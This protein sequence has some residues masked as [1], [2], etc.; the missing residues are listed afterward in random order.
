VPELVA[1]D[2][3]LGEHARSMGAVRG[4]RERRH[5]TAEGDMSRDC[6]W[7]CP[8][9]RRAEFGPGRLHFFDVDSG[10]RLDPESAR[11]AEQLA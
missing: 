7:T 8:D 4:R 9:R 5:P 1:V 6:P 3:D 11:Q 2:P 10:A